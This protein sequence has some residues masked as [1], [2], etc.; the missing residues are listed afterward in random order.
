MDLAFILAAAEHATAVAE[1]AEEHKSETPFFVAGGI[2][3]VY[4]ILVSVYGFKKP[5][6]PATAAAA[7]GIMSAGA[8]L[9]VAAVST[10]IY[11]AI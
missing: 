8:V 7:R 11:V 6:F 2:F 10:A 1:H 9:M 4:A 3:A 5:D